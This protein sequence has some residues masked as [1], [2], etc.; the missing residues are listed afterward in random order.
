MVPAHYCATE[1][2]RALGKP[3]GKVLD[4]FVQAL[5]RPLRCHLQRTFLRRQLSKK[6]ASRL[7]RW[8]VVEPKTP[9]NGSRFMLKW[10]QR[11]GG[12]D[13]CSLLQVA[14]GS[15]NGKFPQEASHLN[16]RRQKMTKMSVISLGDVD[17]H[18]WK[19]SDS[20]V[21]KNIGFKIA[22]FVR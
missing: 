4:Q 6:S 10:T 8:M 20:L 9:V 22:R 12:S 5:S 7:A 17:T 21:A 15:G 14:I 18:N 19:T 3:D 16:V 2:Q 11:S 1:T 13:P